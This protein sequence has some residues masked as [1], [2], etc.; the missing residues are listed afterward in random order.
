MRNLLTLALTLAALFATTGTASAQVPEIPQI[1]AMLPYADAMMEGDALP[2]DGR[3]R[4]QEN[5][6]VYR[7]EAGR[8]ISDMDYV[9][10]F[11]FKVAKDMIVAADFVPGDGN[12]YHGMD[13]GW[14]IPWDITPG[15]NN[16][17][18]IV[19]H[20]VTGPLTLNARPIEFADEDA[21]RSWATGE[22][23]ED[24]D[25]YDDEEDDDSYGE[26]ESE[27]EEECSL[28]RRDEDGDFVCAE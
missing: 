8:V 7:I 11:V 6:R 22:S 21:F 27:E 12:A 2:F 5:N 24:E 28:F 15:P 26:D 18:R 25:E 17:L 14:K 19:I 20:A 1:T 9:D 4:I 16:G 3:W 13:L 10:L 23:A